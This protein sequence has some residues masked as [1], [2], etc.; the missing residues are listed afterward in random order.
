MRLRSLQG[1]STLEQGFREVLDSPS[2]Q[3]FEIQL[4]MA[5]SNLI[6]S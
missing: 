6:Q 5:L 1:C 2:L 3:T 4:D